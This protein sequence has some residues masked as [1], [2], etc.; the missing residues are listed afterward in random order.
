MTGTESP[1]VIALQKVS[2]P[3]YLRIVFAAWRSHAVIAPTE[4]P[5][6]LVLPGMTIAER[7]TVQPGGGWFDE[8]I[9]LDHDPAP[10][11][12]SFTSGTTGTPKPVLLSRRALS[13]VTRRL[14]DV[15]RVDNTIREYVGVPVTFSFG[16]GRARAIAVVGGK[17]YLPATGFR[18]DEFAGMLE[19]GEVNALSAVPTLLRLLIQQRELFD[20]CGGKL[21][22]IEIGSQY[23]SAE[24]KETIRAMFPNARIVQHYG[25]TEAS[26]STFLVVSE[27]E[28]A[29]LESVGR[30]E[31]PDAI[32]VDE[33]GRIM[34]RGH[35]VAEG[36]MTDTGV[37]PLAD[38]SG[39][40]RTSDLGAIDAEGYVYFKGRA[41][42]LLNVSGIKVPAELFEQRL[43]EAFGGDAHRI[44]V[45]GRKDPLR[46]E[47]VMVAHLAGIDPMRL[48]E[49]ARGIAAGFGLGAADVSV[50]EVPEIPRTETG[51]VRRQI[52]TEN[53]SN[54]L[55]TPAPPAHAPAAGGEPMSDR[56]REIAAIWQEVLGIPR[57]G[58]EET[59]FELGGDS[60]SAI[61]AMLRME[62]AGI[63]KDVAQAMLEGRTIAQIAAMVPGERAEVGAQARTSDAINMTRGLLVLIVIAAHWGPFFIERAGRFRAFLDELTNP[64]FRLGTPG[65]AM[66]FGVGLS[67]FY[68]PSLR[69][70]PDRFRAKLRTNALVLVAGVVIMGLAR[71]SALLI[72]GRGLGP[73]WAV[74]LFYSV[75]FFYLLM[76]LSAGPILRGVAR[77]RFQGI[78]ALLCAVIMAMV[79]ALLR[80]WLD[81]TPTTG[82]AELGRLMLVAKYSYPNMLVHVLIGVSIGYWIE[83]EMNAPDMLPK[84]LRAGVALLGAGVVLSFNLGLI[85]AW[86]GAA[87]NELMIVSYAGG[88]LLIFSAMSRL[89]SAVHSGV[90]TFV[91]R[92]LMIIGLLAFPAFVAHESVIGIKDTLVAFHLPYLAAM[93]IPLGL[94]LVAGVLAIRRIYRLYFG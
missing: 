4:H 48:R 92:V 11:Q 7:L 61:G 50:V 82:L 5:D 30:A 88:I 22:W 94:M 19:R 56:E 83:R 13:D 12:I 57:I 43:A 53:Y 47:A 37:E 8:R 28:G 33:E 40:L 65:F 44:A 46:G 2:S 54:A 51:K 49:A 58:R 64:I 93:A 45:A 9:E 74:V 68:L 18:P 63:A 78:D 20:G 41:D 38:A 60:L 66:V 17:A 26:R 29:A 23:M 6:T 27:T 14:N 35:H 75:L 91:A 85:G 16:L 3:D 34:V 39:W 89:R 25:L 24:E 32:R 10:A 21:R 84:L 67:F 59:F 80:I 62:R 86:R 42:H 81:G 87:A 52:L 73:Q 15:M 76:V 90:A 79:S 69:R 70:H 77:M 71:N 31:T 1:R 55:A 36:I 72:E